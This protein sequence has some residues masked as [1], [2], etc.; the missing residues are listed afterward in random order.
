MKPD[1]INALI[2]FLPFF[3]G[4]ETS[5]YRNPFK[6]QTNTLLFYLRP[7]ERERNQSER[8][9]MAISVFLFMLFALVLFMCTWW[10]RYGS[11]RLPFVF[12]SSKSH[13]WTQSTRTFHRIMLIL[14]YRE[15]T[16]G[17]SRTKVRIIWRI[18]FINVKIFWNSNNFYYYVL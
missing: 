4:N 6:S 18:C 5:T 1:K 17:V 9:L 7:R 8:T 11:L 13:T 16:P 14:H 3:P 10:G 2:F 12:N 15:D